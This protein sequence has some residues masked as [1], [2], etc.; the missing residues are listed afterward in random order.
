MVERYGAPP[1]KPRD[2]II[3]RWLPYKKPAERK[4]LVERAAPLMFVFLFRLADLEEL[5]CALGVRPK[6]SETF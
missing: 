3:E 2:V 5:F 4:V 1:P 6:W